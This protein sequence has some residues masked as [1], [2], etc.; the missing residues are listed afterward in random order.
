[1]DST[2]TMVCFGEVL[3]DILPTGRQ[4]GGAPFNVAVHA[5]QLGFNAKLISRVGEDELGHELL[6]FMEEKGIE[7]SSVQRGKTHLTGVVKANVSNRSEVTYQ[8]VQPVAWDYISYDSTVSAWVKEANLF[9]YG[10]LGARSA[11]SRETLYQLL[12]EAN[13]KVFDINL[14]PPHYTRAIVEHLIEKAD[15]VKMNHHELAEVTSWYEYPGEPETAMRHLAERYDLRTVC[16]TRGE[17]G[18]CLLHNDLFYESQGVHVEV[19]DTIGSGDSFLAALLYQLQVNPSTQA[20][21]DFACAT[22]S[23]VATQHGATP[24]LSHTTVESFMQMV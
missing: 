4:A 17:N 11:R 1:M 13:C 2:L 22:G 5:H 20:A 16:V 19:Q 6:A 18:A 23:Y 10:S 8:I 3:W 9:V 15:I 14:R 21:L 7:T 24:T 12:E